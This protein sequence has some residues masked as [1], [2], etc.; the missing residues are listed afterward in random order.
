MET[1]HVLLTHGDVRPLPGGCLCSCL[2]R[3]PWDRRSDLRRVPIHEETGGQLTPVDHADHDGI[4]GDAVLAYA[5][6]ES[7][8]GEPLDGFADLAVSEG[9]RE[10]VDVLVQGMASITAE[11]SIAGGSGSCT[12]M[13]ETLGS[14]ASSVTVVTVAG[15]RRWMS[16]R[17]TSAAWRRLSYVDLR[18][19]V[20]TDED[21]VRNDLG[22]VCATGS[23]SVPDLCAVEN[24]P[25]LVHLV[26]TVRGELR[27]KAGW[28]EL[29]AAAFPPGSVTGAPKAERSA[30]HRHAGDR[31]P[32]PVLRRYRLGRR[33]PRH[34]RARGG[35]SYLLDLPHGR[36]VAFRHGRGHHLGFGPQGGVAGDR[37]E[38]VTAARSGIRGVQGE[39]H[40]P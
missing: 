40:E 21:L 9:R 3:R 15:N 34:G 18:G 13:P 5:F 7:S 25:G 17:P 14:A 4:N 31:A 16:T 22:R 19:G 12:R 10:P 11:A 6:E 39:Y 29:L 8:C 24:H 30:D 23:M 20:V 26:S 2:R 37:T 38:S 1:G 36:S 28:P 35:H 27:E 33:G 32:G